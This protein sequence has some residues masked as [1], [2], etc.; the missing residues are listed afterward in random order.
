MSKGNPPSSRE[1]VPALDGIRAIAVTG[2]ILF[3]IRPG[4]LA[5]GFAGVDVFFVLSGFLI[6]S[7]LTSDIQGGTF[8]FKEFYLRR[9]QRLLPNA[10]LTVA[11]TILLLTFLIPAG[12]EIL[13]ARHGVWTLLN[14]SNIYTHA[15]HGSYWG[16]NAE[17]AYLT[18]FW[19]LGIEEQYYLLFPL[20]LFLASRFVKRG[21]HWFL[22]VAMLAS[23]S[24]CLWAS[25]NRAG[26]A[27]YWLPTRVWELLLGSFLATAGFSISTPEARK[28]HFPR[29]AR[30]ILGWGGTALILASFFMGA[31]HFVFPGWAALFPTL[32]TGAVLLSVATGESSLSR[33]LSTRPFTGVGKVSY[34][35]YLWHWPW[36]VFGRMRAELIDREWDEGAIWGG[37][38]GLAAGVAA[39]FLVE[40][41]MRRR[42]PGRGRRLAALS[43]LFAGTL[44]LCL[45]EAWC[46]PFRTFPQFAPRTVS[47]G[48]YALHGSTPPSVK[49]LSD[50]LKAGSPVHGGIFAYDVTSGEIPVEGVPR[51]VLEKGGLLHLHGGEPPSVV[52]WGSSHAN[53]FSP[54]IDRIC[55]ERKRSV[56]FFGKDAEPPFNVVV[57]VFPEARVKSTRQFHEYKMRWLREWNPD[58]L[59][60]CER[61]DRWY[62]WEEGDLSAFA[63]QLEAFLEEL[64]PLRTKVVFVTQVPVLP[65]GEQMNPRAVAEFRAAPD[66]TLAPF[67][68]PRYFTE[69]RAAILAV[70]EKAASRHPNLRILRTEERLLSP[71]GSIRYCENRQF[72]YFDEDHLNDAG[73]SALAPL[74]SK[75]LDTDA[76]KQP[77]GMPSKPA[78]QK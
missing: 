40:R 26:F 51:K 27:F 29:V 10:T 78:G 48:Y 47:S 22:L 21:V 24:L 31:G 30:E 18:H 54:M 16:T 34:S 11:I 72:Y 19:S 1:H 42:G 69:A 3:H 28:R 15:N 46:K 66:G 23:F 13:T 2:V 68:E 33:L 38:A 52:V 35:L 6:T 20:F 57:K 59:F 4:W 53:M 32:G 49:K 41:P 14:L 61:W 75:F 45:Y 65:H 55:R 43:V 62:A 60:L 67:R 12:L 36:I 25:Y 77:G 9:I 70:V 8:S 64:K 5:G 37:L 76:T 58:V 73:A 39:Y 44:A 56:A 50:P 63:R 71:D 74:F 7:I 17:W